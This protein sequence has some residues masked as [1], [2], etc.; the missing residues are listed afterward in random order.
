L[1]DE[2]LLAVPAGHEW[3]EATV[4]PA[5]QLQQVPFII[6]ERGSGSRHVVEAGLLKAGVRLSSLR[7]AMELDSTEAILSCIEAG[8][9]VGIVSK[10]A[11]D[12]RLRA[13]S[14]ATVA[15]EGQVASS[16]LFCNDLPVVS[17]SG[18]RSIQ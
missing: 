3:A 5:E 1:A 16:L 18:T 9:G 15:I 14:L 13:H 8:L 11:L 6:R 10:W 2:L 12:R 17:T 4:I 7:I